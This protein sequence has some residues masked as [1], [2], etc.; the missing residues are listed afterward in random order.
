MHFPSGVQWGMK[1]VARPLVRVSV[2]CLQFIVLIDTDGWQGGQQ[3]HIKCCFIDFQRFSSGTGK[4]GKPK[5]EAAD[6]G[7]PGT[8]THTHTTVLRLSGFCWGQPTH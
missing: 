8:H 3:D 1:N 2:L 7:L 6:M 5:V 4:R